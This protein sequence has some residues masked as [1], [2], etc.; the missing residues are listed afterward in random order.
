MK[1]R[2]LPSL[3]I[4][5][6]ATLFS[7]HASAQN[8]ASEPT[9]V[10]LPYLERAE[11]QTQP[12]RRYLIRNGGHPVLDAEHP[13]QETPADLPYALIVSPARYVPGTVSLGTTSTGRLAGEAHLPLDGV[14]HYV[15][16]EHQARA[17]HYATEEL[18][19]AILDAGDHFA[20]EYPGERLAIGNMSEREGGDIY[21]SR[22]HNSG[23]DVDIAFPFVDDRN[24]A[25][26]TQNLIAVGRDG[27]AR[28]G[29]GLQMDF[30]RAWRIVEGLLVT[31]AGDVQWI[32]VYRPLKREILAAAERAGAS[33][34]LL[35]IAEQVLHQPGDSAPHNDHFHVRLFCS[36]DDVLEGCIDAGPRRDHAP[37]YSGL[38][39]ARISELTRGLMD[40]DPALAG[41]CFEFLSRFDL[42][43]HLSTLI[44]AL[45]Y[46]TPDVQ[47]RVLDA[48][49]AADEP[50]VT[51]PVVPI[52]ESGLT[53]EVR[54]RAFWMLGRLADQD[55]GYALAGVAQ[56]NAG[57]LDGGASN[58]M[59]AVSA[60]RNIT[61]PR[62][63]PALIDSLTDEDPEVRA[64]VEHVLI[65]TTMHVPS[66]AAADATTLG[67]QAALA[68]GWYSWWVENENV[69][70]EAWLEAAF[71]ERGYA[72]GDLNEAPNLRTLSRATRDE[73]DFVRFNADRQLMRHTGYFT[74]SEGWSERRRS[75]FWRQR[76]G[77]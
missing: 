74:P 10:A 13:P 62:A 66:M 37:N 23:R 34:E 2:Q 49:A 26:T 76:V 5:V 54:E 1:L 21:W 65:R 42:E 12:A 52:A 29:S 22:S 15:M 75:D 40:P 45:P 43:Q 7:G 17:T 16:A 77:R 8:A 47:L 48:L 3:L 44:N 31:R 63:V 57:G 19:S 11:V 25:F 53:S 20:R 24:L 35:A 50:G 70:R 9:S 39:D 59:A 72:V 60:L 64:A 30:E 69:P 38:V 51:G 55:S 68:E 14:N 58:R 27:T 33:P 46:Q 4:S 56:R 71:V 61:D 6:G 18:I 41:G 32:F 67:Q 73:R 28:D 36:R